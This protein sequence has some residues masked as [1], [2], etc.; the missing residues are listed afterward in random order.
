[1]N[2][3]HTFIIICLAI[4]CLCGASS[5]ASF[6][7]DKRILNSVFCDK[8]P[9]ISNKLRKV[10]TVSDSRV[11]CLPEH[12][13]LF[14]FPS[15]PLTE[16]RSF[17]VLISQ[18]Q[19]Q[20]IP[21]QDGVAYLF[22]LKCNAQE[23]KVSA[24]FP[25][26]I[27]IINKDM[28]LFKTLSL[29]NKK[30]IANKL[31]EITLLNNEKLVEIQPFAKEKTLAEN[32]IDAF[33]GCDFKTV[34]ELE[35][36]HIQLVK[37]LEQSGI[38]HEDLHNSNILLNLVGKQ[39]FIIDWVSGGNIKSSGFESNTACYF[40]KYCLG[41]APYMQYLNL[42]YSDFNLFE[43][44]NDVYQTGLFYWACVYACSESE[45]HILEYLY[46]K[47]NTRSLLNNYDDLLIFNIDRTV[48]LIAE[49]RA[50]R[51]CDARFFHTNILPAEYKELQFKD[52]TII[53]SWVNN[54]LAQSIGYRVSDNEDANKLNMRRRLKS[55]IQE[56]YPD[57]SEKIIDKLKDITVY[58]QNL[59]DLS[60]DETLLPMKHYSYLG[61]AQ[62]ALCEYWGF[63]PED[64]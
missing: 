16:L 32:F 3:L 19:S 2:K 48:D 54:I 61:L 44:L 22:N 41:Y 53:D 58:L 59:F 20:N 29:N 40:T 45:Q 13:L 30:D 8:F 11:Y 23:Y 27:G 31:S 25:R 4:I 24:L 38:V 62:F 36:I 10:S 21:F 15:Y 57:L 14:K 37:K 50:E 34:K 39:I 43:L 7:E 28:Q 60:E 5:H 12:S 42:C 55:E 17:A 18:L 26:Y 33:S 46:F 9:G 64:F 52:D 51:W 6:Q 35:M 56:K 47:R 1:M 49:W 63:T